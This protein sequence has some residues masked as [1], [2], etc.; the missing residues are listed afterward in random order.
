MI[1]KSVVFHKVNL[2][3]YAKHWAKRSYNA[4]PSYF[5][6]PLAS[7][8]LFTFVAGCG[9][10]GT[11]L[12]AAKLANHSEVMGIGRETNVVAPGIHSL[13]SVK[14][15]ASEWKYFSESLGHSCVLEK[16][17]KHV[18]SYHRVQKV[19]PNN[20]FIIMI[21]NPLD[22]I[23]SLYQRFGDVDFCVERW[24][25]DNKE[26]INISCEKNVLLVRYEELTEA[27]EKKIGEVLQF[28]GLDY[29]DSILSSEDTIYNRVLQED[30]MKIRQE[31]VS[32]PITPNNGGWNK[33]FSQTEAKNIMVKVEDIAEKLGYTDSLV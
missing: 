29:E 19:I 26:A 27:P 1:I 32:K 28:L 13:N 11:T 21:R 2:S 25:F 16:T 31:Q 23:A 9:H 8:T 4:L 10:S 12:M 33:V 17:P 18:Y 20:K 3:S 30:N 7:D 6:K 5:V 14:A 24:I 22:T 15:I